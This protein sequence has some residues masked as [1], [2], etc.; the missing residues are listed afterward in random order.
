MVANDQILNKLQDLHEILHQKFPSPDIISSLSSSFA[1]FIMMD[2]QGKQQSIAENIQRS[3]DSLPGHENIALAEIYDAGQYEALHSQYNTKIRDLIDK[4]LNS[5][6]SNF[7]EEY[8]KIQNEFL[9]SVKTKT[10]EISNTLGVELYEQIGSVIDKEYEELIM[11]DN[12]NIEA[13]LEIGLT[14]IVDVDDIKEMTYTFQK[15]GGNSKSLRAFHKTQVLS[16]SKELEAYKHAFSKVVDYE[17]ELNEMRGITSEKAFAQKQGFNELLSYA[18]NV[19]KAMDGLQAIFAVKYEIKKR[20]I[21]LE[22]DIHDLN[23]LCDIDDKIKSIIP[24]NSIFGYREHMIWEAHDSFDQN[25]EIKHD[26][27]SL[28]FETIMQNFSQGPDKH[29][30]ASAALKGFIRGPYMVKGREKTRNIIE[31]KLSQTVAKLNT[32]TY[33]GHVPDGHFLN[34]GDEVHL[35]EDYTVDGY[36]R[37]FNKCFIELNKFI[38][39]EMISAPYETEKH[40][41]LVNKCKQVKQDLVASISKKALKTH[42]I[43]KL[44][45]NGYP[46]IYGEILISTMARQYEN[47]FDRELSRMA[48][49]IE[50]AVEKAEPSVEKIDFSAPSLHKTPNPEK[51]LDPLLHPCPMH[52]NQKTARSFRFILVQDE[53]IQKTWFPWFC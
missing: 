11:R 14:F 37:E 6:T 51:Q 5:G 46:P 43:E 8:N 12:R 36:E 15:N 28:L 29:Q 24:E 21:D 9:S 50:L 13:S 26:K 3:L 31:E 44:Q 2:P 18:E 40:T 22:T 4:S 45:D 33:Y 48:A 30:A 38:Y 1:N 20:D 19:I 42:T 17:A 23:D 32:E 34:P 41:L 7:L 53:K 47:L 10:I 25:K 27:S 49:S 16:L 52:Q 35:L 39:Q